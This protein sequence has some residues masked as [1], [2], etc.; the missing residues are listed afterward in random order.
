MA[1]AGNVLVGLGPFGW[2]SSVE[3]DEEEVEY[4]TLSFFSF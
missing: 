2:D 4:G 1:L 3:R